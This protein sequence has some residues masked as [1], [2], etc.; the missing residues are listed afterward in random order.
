MSLS[1]HMYFIFSGKCFIEHFLSKIYFVFSCFY[2]ERQ[3]LIC[4]ISKQSFS[5]TLMKY[6]YCSF[7]T[8][9][10]AFIGT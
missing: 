10:K 4:F 9:Y 1:K 3:G 8:L 7:V 6:Q 2:F 5:G